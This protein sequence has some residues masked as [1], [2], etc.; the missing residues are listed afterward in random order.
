MTPKS[1]LL[2]I[3]SRTLTPKWSM[4]TANFRKTSLFVEQDYEQQTSL[5]YRMLESTND[6]RSNFVGHPF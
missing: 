4:N 1:D 5:I 2:I 3:G 6:L